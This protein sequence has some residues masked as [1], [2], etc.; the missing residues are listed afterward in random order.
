MGEMSEMLSEVTSLISRLKDKYPNEINSFLTFMERA[1]SGPALNARE[2][3]LINV[4]IAV[5]TQ[6]QWCIAVHVKHAVAAG[7]TRAQLAE[8]GFMAVLMHGGPALMYLVP[9]FKALDEFLPEGK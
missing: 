5:A 2:K 9:L 4:G 7:A 3:E 1:E 6:C 8:A